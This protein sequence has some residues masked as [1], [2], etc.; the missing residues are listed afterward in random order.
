M[1]EDHTGEN[2]ASVLKDLLQEWDIS[3]SKIGAFTTDCGSNVVRCMSILCVQRIS[4]F[5]HV[6]NNAVCKAFDLDDISNII[7]KV[8]KNQNLFAHS[9]KIQ[10]ELSKY[11]KQYM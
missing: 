7:G 3:E 11:Q 5:G 6:L 8:K 4:C 2:W 10:N 1:S 9:W